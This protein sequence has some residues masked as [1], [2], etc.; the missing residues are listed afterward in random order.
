[1]ASSGKL[2]IQEISFDPTADPPTSMRP[3]AFLMER[4]S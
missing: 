4:M 2:E 1:V 3:L